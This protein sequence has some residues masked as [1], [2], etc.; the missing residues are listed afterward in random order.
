MDTGEKITYAPSIQRLLSFC[1]TTVS[2]LLYFSLIL[3]RSST[4]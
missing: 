1:L 3:E 4:K 2:K